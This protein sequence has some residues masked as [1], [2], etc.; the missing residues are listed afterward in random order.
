[1]NHTPATVLLVTATE[2]ESRAVLRAF[3]PVA[4]RTVTPR[5]IDG[6]I[7]FDLGAVNGTAAFLV[8]SE[9]GAGGLGA[10]QQTVQKGIE[11]L[12]P[13]AVVMVGIAF[14]VN[15]HQQAIGDVL[16]TEQLRLYDLQRVG[17]HAGRVQIVLRGDK[18]HASPWLINHF[19]SARLLWEGARVRFGVV[20]T[21]EKLVDNV[22]FR[23]QLR[24]FEPEAI[25]GEMEGAGLYVSCQDRKVDWILIKAICDWADGH[26]AQDKTARQQIAA[27]N[28][29]AFVLHAL[30]FAPLQRPGRPMPVLPAD[31]SAPA[32]R[33]ALPAQPLFFGRAKELALVADAIAPQARTWGVLIDGPGGIGKTALAIRAGRLAPTAHFPCKLFLS[34]KVRELTPQ[35]EQPLEDFMLRNY[36][37]LLNEL[38]RELGIA[39][40]EKLPENERANAVRRALEN[41]RVLLVIDNVETFGEPERMRLYQFLARLPQGCKA[42]VTSRRRSDV[43]ARTIRLDRLE[44]P[45]AL[46][47]LAELS[48]S[49]RLLAAAGADGRRTL[50][51]VTNGNPLLIR[52]TTGQLGR[53]GSRCRT[54][55]EACALLRSAPGDNDPLAFIFGDVLDTFTNSESTILAALTHFREPAKVEWLADI[56]RLSE[57]EVRTALEDLADRALLVGDP[58]AG[59][60]LLPGLTA[61]FLRRRCAEAAAQAGDRLAERALG[62]GLE[63]GYDNY[64]R[65]PVLEAAW[66]Q[67]AAALPLLLAGDNASLQKLCAALGNFLEFSGRWDECLALSEQAEQRA[68]AAGDFDNAGWRAQDA[69]WVY[70]LRNQAG[71]VLACAR[72]AEE[73]WWRAG[74]GAPERAAAIHLRGMGHELE[75]NYPAAT[76]AYQQA[77]ALHRTLGAESKEVASDLSSLAD[78]E[79]LSG[80]Y[81]AAERDYREALRIAQKVADHEGVAIYTGS[82]AE[83]ALDREDYPSAEQLAREA[84]RLD[85]VIGRLELIGLVCSQLARA[86]ARQSRAAEGVPYARRAV[87]IFKRLRMPEELE[88]AQA[89]LRECEAGAEG[90]AGD[91]DA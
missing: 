17:T 85:E 14:G 66:P 5:A 29:V 9:M 64:E 72:H 83:L 55:A 88:K 48:R 69:G 79:H 60:F 31:A 12:A 53:P 6:R 10:A 35:G 70:Y 42:I 7:Y 41:R 74:T 57:P 84:L 2:I 47:L 52:W 4:G 62:L 51:E 15:E 73:H 40:I 75:K 16:V 86:L 33:S 77:L 78:V 82:L 34:A 1:M 20:L 22:D 36:V 39:H 63:N 32:V 26:K 38:A 24:G 21:G 19:K 90:A 50:Y 54:V 3:G 61:H 27:A 91:A 58:Q 59:L 11:A 25:G 65:F 89:A 44:A 28:A 76:A 18:P 81:A 23:E 8:Q 45:D 43:D 37:A 46:A 80:N 30:Q 87:E 67:V 68:V 71:N 56:A 49:N 13:D